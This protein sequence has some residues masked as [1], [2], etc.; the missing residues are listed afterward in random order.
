VP[1]ITQAS[2]SVLPGVKP[3]QQSFVVAFADQ[4]LIKEAKRL[5]RMPEA[6]LIHVEDLRLGGLLRAI[7]V[8]SQ[9]A[10]DAAERLIMGRIHHA[11]Q[12]K[13]PFKFASFGRKLKLFLA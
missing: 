6:K 13:R 8:Q 3:T 7:D 5:Q 2:Q 1:L 11:K 10:F 12:I 9:N 4:E